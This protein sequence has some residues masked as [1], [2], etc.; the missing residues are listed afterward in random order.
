MN[1]TH[2]SLK[3]TKFYHEVKDAVIR[4]LRDENKIPPPVPIPASL[5]RGT[6]KK[7]KSEKDKSEK[8]KNEK[9]KNEKDVNEKEEPQIEKVLLRERINR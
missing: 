7:E 6:A 3:T 4:G 9:E 5:L 1:S 2:D 8:E